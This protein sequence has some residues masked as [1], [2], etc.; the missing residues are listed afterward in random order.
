M[1]IHKKFYFSITM[2]CFDFS[3]LTASFFLVF[4]EKLSLYTSIQHRYQNNV[5][6]LIIYAYCDN[7]QVMW[8]CQIICCYGLYIHIATPQVMWGGFYIF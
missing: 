1:L 2:G 4:G 8:H 7:P 3:V 5:L 6:L